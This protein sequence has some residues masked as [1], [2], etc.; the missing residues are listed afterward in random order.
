M[1]EIAK[2]MS[3]DGLI[4]SKSGVGGGIQLDIDPGEWPM[5]DVMEY[6]EIFD[7]TVEP[8]DRECCVPPE[9]NQCALELI[10]TKLDQDLFKQRTLDEFV[11]ELTTKS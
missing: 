1:G 6:L 4:K 5:T 10:E 3:S 7:H 9:F 11:D 2:E 8:G